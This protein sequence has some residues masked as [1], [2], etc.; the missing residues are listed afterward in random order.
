M[1][2]GSPSSLLPPCHM[3]VVIISLKSPE[4]WL[5]SVVNRSILLRGRVGADGSVYVRIAKLA[6]E[7]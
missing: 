7:T 6:W 1:T 3:P 5:L 4:A 2:L